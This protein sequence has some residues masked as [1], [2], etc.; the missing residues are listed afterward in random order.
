MLLL[1]TCFVCR[2]TRMLFHLLYWCTKCLQDILR[3]GSEVT[4]LYLMPS[5]TRRWRTEMKKILRRIAENQLGFT[6][7]RVR[8]IKLLSSSYITSPGIAA[9]PLHIFFLSFAWFSHW[10]HDQE[11]FQGQDLCYRH[12]ICQ[13]GAHWRGRLY[14][15]LEA[16]SWY[17]DFHPSK[18]RRTNRASTSKEDN[19]TSARVFV[20][21]DDFV[22]PLD[23]AEADAPPAAA[24]APPAAA[25]APPPEA[26]A[27]GG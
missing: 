4:E 10:Q 6:V 8:F 14:I 11:N 18:R 19:V 24:D 27:G 15:E 7:V 1:L 16:S 21:V 23:A 17:K 26:A 13:R 5:T 20:D 25:D 22:D 3:N 12:I 9:D 2:Y